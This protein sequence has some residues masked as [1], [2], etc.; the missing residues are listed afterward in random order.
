MGLVGKIEWGF[1][2]GGGSCNNRF[3]PKCE[4]AIAGEVSNS[5]KN[6]LAIADLFA[7]KTQQ[8]QLFEKPLL[9]TPPFAIPNLEMPNFPNPQAHSRP[10]CTEIAILNYAIAIAANFH[11]RPEIA[12]ISGTLMR[13]EK[14]CDFKLQIS[15]TSDCDFI[16]R[17][18]SE[19]HALS[20]GFP[21]DPCPSFALFFFF[22][23]RARKTTREKQGSFCPY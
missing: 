8:I 4:V 13:R 7:K 9:G 19:N 6:S 5:G 2:E 3:V 22:S 16:L 11:R 14:H 10:E 1:S 23:K 21:C 12:A 17:N 20:R 18:P 15:I